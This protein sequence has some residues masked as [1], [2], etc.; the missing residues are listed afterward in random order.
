MDE[1][2][3]EVLEECKKINEEFNYFNFL[4]ESL[5]E[6]GE[7]K[8]KGLYVSI[9]DC[10]C[11]KDMESTAGSRILKTYKPVF[12]ATI[13]RKLKEEGAVIIGKTSQDAFGFGSFNT[14]VGLDYKIPKNPLD[15]ERVTGGSS[16]GGAGLTKVAKFNHVAI[17]ESTG[18]SIE[19]P[20]A[21]CGVVGFCPTYGRVS[22]YGLISYANSLDKIGIMSKKVS[23]IKPVLEIISGHDEKDATSLKEEVNFESNIG[24]FKVGVIKEFLKEGVDPGI[25]K[26]MDGTVAKLKTRG[27]EVSEVSLPITFKYGIPT[28][29]IIS[30]SEASSNLAKL[31]GLRYGQQDNPKNK[32]F[33]Q[34]FTEIRS[35]NFNEES[36]RRIILGTF[37]RMAGYRDAYYLKATKVRTKI[38]DE[39][40][41]LFETYDV[42]ISPT[43][44]VIAPK[45]S[46]VEK[47]TTL[48]SYMMD[49]LTVGPNLAGVPHASIP[50]SE[51]KGIPVGM[52][53]AA[54]HLK[55]GKLLEFLQL[56]EEN[57][58]DEMTGGKK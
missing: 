17:T 15:K 9:K 7:G 27:I 41:K 57:V 23:E 42:L 10:I 11:I 46:E 19:N 22:R 24:K 51:I 32:T 5:Q 20:A 25:K 4:P 2:N 54:D 39:Y 29:Y 21:F 33:N 16:G 40:K 48:E 45:F 58:N 55:E 34:Y 53:V 56:V 12:D 26:V 1:K 13:V 14:N 8:L 47:M 44:P 52:M 38:I 49:I 50:I 28:Y 35:A 31:S 37:A 36:K 30:T 3:K 6:A 43:M 18:G